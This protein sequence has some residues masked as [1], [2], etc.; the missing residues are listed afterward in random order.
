MSRDPLER[1]RRYLS[2]AGRVDDEAEQ[3]WIDELQGECDRAMTRLEEADLP[4]RS[5]AVRHTYERIP[6]PVV[7]HLRSV[8]RDLGEEP[9]EF[10]EAEVFAPD[11]EGAL[12]DGS[13]EELTHV[14]AIRSAMESAMRRDPTMIC[15]GEDIG[16]DGGC[17]K[18]T[19]GFLDEFGPDRV[20]DSPL[21]ET[22]IVGTAV[23]MALH[24][25][26]V[27]AELQLA[28]FIY[29]ALDQTLSHVSRI[30]SRYQGDLACPIV[31]RAPGGGGF[32]GLEFHMDCPEG[33]LMAMPGTTIVASSDPIQ[34]KGLLSAALQHPD[35]VVFLEPIA[36]YRTERQAVPLDDYVVPLGRARLVRPGD[37]VT[38]VTYGRQVGKAMLAADLAAKEGISTEVIDLRTLRPWDE[39]TVLESVSRTRRLIT[40]HDAHRAAGV[41]AEVATR[42]TEELFDSMAAPPVRVGVF[43]VNRPV[44]RCEKLMEVDE[45]WILGAIRRTTGAE[46]RP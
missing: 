32:G 2:D 31:I 10:S 44:L 33:L 14:Q 27:M 23:G 3:A 13:T 19:E 45:A 24:G 5:F 29:P 34:A 6:E 9:T 20:I 15:I 38:I 46:G 39:R 22:G 16:A 28:G 8:Q 1:M 18:A 43:D 17:F 21:C 25:N 12:P 30:R 41:G 36:T 26:R 35:P 42:V 40:V 37:D 4:P 7:Q 11:E